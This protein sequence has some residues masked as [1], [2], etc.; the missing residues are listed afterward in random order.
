MKGLLDPHLEKKK[1][2]NHTNMQRNETEEPVDLYK[3]V[4]QVMS[5]ENLLS[6]IRYIC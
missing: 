2:D 4:A 1:L 6:C 5:G 3:G